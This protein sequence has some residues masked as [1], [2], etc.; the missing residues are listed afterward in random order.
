MASIRKLRDK[1]QVQ[2]RIK[3]VSP[4]TRSFNRKSEASL[5][6]VETE[7]QIRGNHLIDN[8]SIASNQIKFS[9]VVELYREHQKLKS[10]LDGSLLSRLKLLRAS[11]GDFNVNS[12]RGSDL[13][14][15]RNQRL[16]SVSEVTVRHEL[17]LINRM[18]KFASS[19]LDVF[20]PN[21]IPSVES[22]RLPRGRSRRMDFSE[23]TKILQSVQSD[24][25]LETFILLAIETGA[26]RSELVK[27]DQSGF[28]EN[29]GTFT[30][31]NTKN[32]KDR[33]V[34]LSNKA[35]E[36]VRRAEFSNYAGRLFGSSAEALSHRFSRLCKRV[37]V[38]GLRL[39]DLRHEAISRMFENGLSAV[40][41]A[42]ISGHSNPA[43]LHR[44]TH[45]SQS[46]LILKMRA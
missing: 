16:L 12:I 39:H 46:Y 43:I 1:W 15:Y 44:Y 27:V 18:L 11:L 4:V 3:G 20:F 40:E 37:G 5:W 17:G 24:P 13:A 41:V 14:R 7:A 31:R 22:P 19:E 34:P 42:E 33:T 8:E 6:A 45:L 23:E 38:K 10:V 26:R 9:A 25:E 35:M 32:G 29:A 2:I 30:F 28:D 36:I 21:G